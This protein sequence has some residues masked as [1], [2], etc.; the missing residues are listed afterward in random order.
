MSV[1][2]RVPVSR[3]L[4]ARDH[5]GND[6]D[7]QRARRSRCE[8]V[9]SAPRSVA[10]GTPRTTE[11]KRRQPCV[12]PT[13]DPDKPVAQSFVLKQHE[14]QYDQH[15]PGGLD[16]GPDRGQHFC[17]DLPGSR[18][19]LVQSQPG[20]RGDTSGVVTERATFVDHLAD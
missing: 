15:N 20:N 12:D 4:R 10:C 3:R 2:A 8:S 7:R 13:R 6:S 16:D 9:A 18:A 14:H 17:N 1:S 5:P 19:G 11:R